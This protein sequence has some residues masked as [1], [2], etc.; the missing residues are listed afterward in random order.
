MAGGAGQSRARR[1]PTGYYAGVQLRCE[2]QIVDDPADKAEQLR[3]LQP[4]HEHAPLTVDDPPYA[5]LLPGMRGLRLD[6]DVVAK[7][8]FDDHK[9]VQHRLAVAGRLQQR[10]QGRD[11]G[12]RTEQLRRLHAAEAGST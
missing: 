10:D 4:E 1:V 8:E 7:F 2:A 3:S 9:S 11:R 12:A 6:V 5:R